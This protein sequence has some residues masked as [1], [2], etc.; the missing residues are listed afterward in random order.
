MVCRIE[1]N[2]QNL[3]I[4]IQLHIHFLQTNA[5]E[6][7]KLKKDTRQPQILIMFTYSE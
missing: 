1:N 7:D 2:V 5:L 4:G 6:W 3:I